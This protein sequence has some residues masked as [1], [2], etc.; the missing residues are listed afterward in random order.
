MKTKL[1]IDDD[2][3]KG[4]ECLRIGAHTNLDGLVNDLLRSGL[5]EMGVR[6]LKVVSAEPN[7]S[8]LSEPED[9]ANV[10][11]ASARKKPNTLP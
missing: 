8:Q 3:V 4:L 1:N 7:N 9:Q 2:V 10:P 6:S 11:V 5:K